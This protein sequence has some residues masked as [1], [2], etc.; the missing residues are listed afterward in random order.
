MNIQE[1]DEKF[2]QQELAE[3]EFEKPLSSFEKKKFLKKRRII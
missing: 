2:L 1:I 3:Y